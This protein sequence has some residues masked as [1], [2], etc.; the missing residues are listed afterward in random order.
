MCICV[1]VSMRVP[2]RKRS[3]MHTCKKKINESNYE[4]MQMHFLMN[5][6]VYVYV[7]TCVYVYM[8]V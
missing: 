2:I 6:G 1:Y 3:Y 8:C 5:G 4:S 7:R